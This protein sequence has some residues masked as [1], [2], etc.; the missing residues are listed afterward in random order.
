MT[1]KVF[2]EDPYRT[3][4]RT[5]VTDV[6]GNEIGVAETI[7]F[8]FAGGQESDAGSLGG[9]SVVEVRTQ[10]HDIRYVLEDATGLSPGD[11]VEMH[12]DWER[13]Y[14]LMR[15]HFAAEIVLELVYRRF[16]GIERVGAHI[17]ADRARLDFR[18]P[19]NVGPALE[20]LREDAQAIVEADLPITSAF[21]DEVHE[22]RYWEIEGFARVDCAGTHLRRTGEVGELSLRRRNPGRGK[23]RIEI[24]VS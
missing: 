2:W 16:A 10:D 23:E 22:R 19:E 14:A 17:A 13:R 5:R 12:I 6:Q 1:R 9:R 7:F 24:S 21:S 4:L 8:A 3:S 15:L 11:V 20:E 18:W